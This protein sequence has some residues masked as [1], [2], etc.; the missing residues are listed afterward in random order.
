MSPNS[1]SAL[2]WTALALAAGA[3]VTDVS[4]RRVP[5]I[6]TFGGAMAGVALN[7]ALYGP[8]GILRSLIGL[9]VGL[10]VFLPIF[11]VRGLGGGDVKLL[12]A[13]GAIIGA[14]LV[15]WTALYGA[16]AGGVL[17]V[18][19]AL[20]GGVLIKSLNNILFILTQWRLAG[21]AP[22]DGF[23]LDNSTSV[24]LPYALPLSCGLLVA[25]W[26]QG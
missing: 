2:E 16:I 15:I 13:F 24:R 23:T 11:A 14:R 19:F 18:A 25:L 20:A 8:W 17:G 10:I 6:L 3:C 5:N 26:L 9:S 4:R 22:V 1:Y 7:A 12:A 21:V